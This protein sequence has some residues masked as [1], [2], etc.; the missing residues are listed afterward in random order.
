MI[1]KNAFGS[2][3]VDGKKYTT[4][5]LIYPDGRVSDNWWRKHGHRLSLADIE[6]LVATAPEMIV[7]G[8]GVYG[9]MLP[10]AGLEK[11]LRK[12]GIKLVMDPTGEA[13]ACF[14][15]LRTTR[16]IGGGFHLTC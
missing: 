9:R 6:A 13:I 2:I 7:I 4:D 10:E 16:K 12:R 3:Q 8:T 1:E 15:R 14:N 5:I 11:E